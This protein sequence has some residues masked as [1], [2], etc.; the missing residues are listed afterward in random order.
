M[1]FDPAVFDAV[2]LAGGTGRRLGG[3]DKAELV[4][5][6]TRLLDVVIGACA[7]SARTVVVGPQRSTARAVTWTQ[8]E[9]P[10]G[11]PCAALAAGLELVTAPL[12]V[13]LAV[14]L[15]HLTAETVARLVAA[16]PVVAVDDDGREQWLLSAWPTDA[17]HDLP[18]E[19][20]LGR[21]LGSLSY[22]TLPVGSAV[23]DVD[24]ADDLQAAADRISTTPP[25]T[26]TG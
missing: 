7:G 23:H 22:A 6:G 18:T 8:E 11:G 9:P 12:T 1:A 13:V 14:D 21:A 19:G 16:A 24:T 17:L 2:V 25:T 10:G 26:R 5:A 15:P 20:S 4:V 3:Q